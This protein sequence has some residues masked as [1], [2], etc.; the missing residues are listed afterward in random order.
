MVRGWVQF[1]S[2]EFGSVGFGFSSFGWVSFEG[3]KQPAALAALPIRRRR[4]KLLPDEQQH[5]AEGYIYTM[6]WT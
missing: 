2:V 6:R 3:L 1:S 4:P 5:N